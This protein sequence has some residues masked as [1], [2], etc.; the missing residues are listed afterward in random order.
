MRI[1]IFRLL[2]WAMSYMIFALAMSVL[3]LKSSLFLISENPRFLKWTSAPTR[4]VD[5]DPIT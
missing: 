3:L 1:N 5:P 4:D 2:T